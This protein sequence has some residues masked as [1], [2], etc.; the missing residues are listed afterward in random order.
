[1]S[2][3]IVQQLGFDASNALSSL[4]QLDAALGTFESRLSASAAAMRE[5]NAVGNQTSQM[6]SRLAGNASKAA[7]ALASVNTN[8]LGGGGAA[9]AA[10]AFANLGTLTQGAANKVAAG[11]KTI[12]TA[13]DSAATA[14]ASNVGKMTTSLQLLS[15][16]AFTQAVVRALSTLRNSIKATADEAIQLQKSVALIQTIDQSG[17]SA[18]SLTSSIR[19]ISDQ[20]NIPQ[21]QVAEGLYQ[22][23]SNQ[24]GNA[25]QSIEFMTT[26][27]KFARAT[28]SSLADSVDLISGGLKAFNLDISEA[29]RVAGVFFKSIDLGRVTATQL[30]ND[31]GRV[32]PQSQL[33]GLTLEELGA[34]ISAI[35]IKG[36]DA[37]QAMTQYRGI[38]TAIQK[39]TEAMKEAVT[40]A[41]FASTEAAVATLNLTGFLKLLADAAG[42]SSNAMAAFFPNVRGLSGAASLT[43]EDLRVL[44]DYLN[45]MESVTSKNIDDKFLIAVSTDAERVTSD[46][47]KLKNALT[48]ELGQAFLKVAVDISDFVGGVDK[49][50]SLI[51]QA[52]P[53]VEGLTL[54]LGSLAVA[55]GVARLAGGALFPALSGLLLLPTAIG[56]LRSLGGFIDQKIFEANFADLNELIGKDK[57]QL[58]TLE[59]SINETLE[60]AKS[61]DDERVKS[62]TDAAKAI[63][64][65]YNN[66]VSDAQSLNKTL[67]KGLKADAN[68]I[69][70]AYGKLSTALGSAIAEAQRSKESALDKISSLQSKQAAN[71]LQSQIAGLSDP[72]KVFA[73]S[74]KSAQLA[75][76]AAA[77]IASGNPGQVKQ[78]EQQAAVAQQLAEQELQLAKQT[79]DRGLIAKAARDLLNVQNAQIAAEEKLAA[80]EDKRQSQL[81]QEKANVDKT[82]NSIKEQL[83]ILLENSGALDKNGKKFSEAEQAQRAAK[84]AAASTSLA[85]LALN[86]ADLKRLT[87]LGLG[88]VVAKLGSQL[89]TSPVKLAFD[90]DQGIQRVQDKITTAFASFKVKFGFDTSA[91]EQALGKTFANPDQLF[92][93]LNDAKAEIASIQKQLGDFSKSQLAHAQVRGELASAVGTALNTKPGAGAFGF[94]QNADTA[95]EGLVNT[96]GNLASKVNITGE[97]IQF[98]AARVK[99]F[100]EA[101]RG[102]ADT[103]LAYNTV[104]DALGVMLNRLEALSEAQKTSL[105]PEQVQAFQARLQA[106][107]PLLE[108]L[109]N[110][111]AANFRT[112]PSSM[113]AAVSPAESIEA[114]S[115][116]VRANYEA[117]MQAAAQASSSSGG[118]VQGLAKGGLV[119]YYADGGFT[120][121]GT[122]TI[123]AM[124]SPGEFVVNAAATRQFYSQLVAINSGRSPIYRAEG[125]PTTQNFHFGDINVVND[126]QRNAARD[127][128]NSIRREL[129]R[130][131]S[132][133]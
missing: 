54:S 80:A 68:D 46:I 6:L 111:T 124:L 93:G 76:E 18:G 88:A 62:A 5:F 133:F 78:G 17:Q 96:F 13:T 2:D 117:A 102:V 85:N 23:I 39:P 27:A 4:A 32:A 110:N 52:P 112:I 45:Q 3:Q 91:L 114:S 10:A 36:T 123:P 60:A 48:D 105:S 38:V 64:A 1:M 47:N 121:R 90:A 101:T 40:S 99:E 126:G 116:R 75:A 42:G 107:E 129:R 33:A 115:A 53:L 25:T 87:D 15:R 122:D 127:V 20:F 57:E 79:G 82:T 63:T 73:L 89:T 12:K 24:I 37:S 118:Q 106:L 77:K 58:K 113:Q 56:A 84:V 119:H 69:I 55:F 128:V 31:I 34:A 8:S 94:S 104:N 61:A 74:Q 65:A 70:S 92:K 98:A 108:S 100:Q 97:D 43:S 66:E 81:T 59:E 26:A 14:T 83:A 30:A 28:N 22:T 35:S 41:G 72:Q 29:D 9:Q 130:T 120:P 7:T 125:G 67:V 16:I 50:T 109:G 19:S 103:R 21:L 132:K 51:A 95:L 86:N 71:A 11:T 44:I 131:T 49:F